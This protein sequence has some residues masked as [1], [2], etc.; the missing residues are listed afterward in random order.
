MFGL[1]VILSCMP[2]FRKVVRF[3]HRE[4]EQWQIGAKMQIFSATSGMISYAVLLSKN[5]YP[6]V[7]FYYKLIV[8]NLQG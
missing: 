8:I 6:V 2:S 7:L 5:T 1:H 4:G 3:V